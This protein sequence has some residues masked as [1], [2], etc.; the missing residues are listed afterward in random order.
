MN[1]CPQKIM[2]ASLGPKDIALWRHL[3][4]THGANPSKQSFGKR[5]RH[6]TE[7]GSGL[8]PKKLRQIPVPANLTLLLTSFSSLGTPRLWHNNMT[9]DCQQELGPLIV[10]L[11]QSWNYC[12]VSC[13]SVYSA[14]FRGRPQT[15]VV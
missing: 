15:S 1:E 6:D 14:I 4:V 3:S 7:D 10:L 12:P 11:G 13:L 5:R 2:A 9:T 8:P